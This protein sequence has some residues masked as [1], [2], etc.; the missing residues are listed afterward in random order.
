MKDILA[1]LHES[2]EFAQTASDIATH[3]N[4]V[5]KLISE[6]VEGLVQAEQVQQV[7]KKR[8]RNPDLPKQPTSNYFYFC[9]YL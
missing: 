4:T 6:H 1:K 2:P 9:N 7:K 3:L 5:S 8:E